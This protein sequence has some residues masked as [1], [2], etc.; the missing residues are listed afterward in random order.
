MAYLIQAAGGRAHDG[1]QD[2]LAVQP[3]SIHQR[4]PVFLGS[5]TD[6]ERI[7]ELYAEHGS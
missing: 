4:T 6:V 2:V 3:T 1:Q 7:I 5:T